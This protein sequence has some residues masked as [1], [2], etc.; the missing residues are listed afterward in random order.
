MPKSLLIQKHCQVP[1]II[2]QLLAHW[3]SPSLFVRSSPPASF[4]SGARHLRRK[5]LI[6]VS[7][8]LEDLNFDNLRWVSPG[9]VE[10]EL[11]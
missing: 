7:S 6:Q 8:G 11:D 5:R 2:S 1:N 9:L 10:Q 4:E 3:A